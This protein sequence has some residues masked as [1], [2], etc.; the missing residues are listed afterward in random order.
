MAFDSMTLSAIV[1]ELR[2][3]LLGAKINK[4]HQPDPHTVLLKCH[5]QAGALRLLLSAHP[6]NGRIVCTE[7]NRE[8]PP[9]APLFL[10]VL[11]KWLEGARI[12]DFSCT[13]GERVATL[14]AE[15]RDELGDLQPLHLVTEIMGKHSN[16]ILY[17]REGVIIDGIRRYG[18]HLSRYREVLPGKPYLPPPPMDRLPLPP[19][20]EEALAELLYSH[21][22]QEISEI[23]R[24][25]IKG[26]SPLLAEHIL[27]EAGL[28]G[29]LSPD[30]MG[31]YEIHRI[32]SS[33]NDLGKMCREA[34][35][36]PQL[37]QVN[38]RFLDFAA[39]SPAFWPE[40]ERL[41]TASMNQAVDAFYQQREE[42][43]LFRRSANAL[44]R[45]L[46]QNL[47]RL[48]KKISLEE[49]DLYQSEAADAY[50]DCGDL[51]STYLWHLQKGMEQV[52]LPSFYD[53][54][55]KILVKL[56]PAL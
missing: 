12:T 54:E 38:G 20:S 52:E 49:A 3:R 24:R 42:E 15:C 50:K 41:E 11:R 34:R 14:D 16:I 37:R 31:E 53:P 44:N 27:T 1:A 25:G 36:Q 48:D 56:D 47:A 17:N 43:Q 21:G 23:L 28:D 19:D 22:E 7:S 5:S 51:L 29:E 6:E 39:L 33:L 4:I 32:Y 2:P 30:Q 55:E 35:F 45:S 26:L 18:S 13:D 40:D 9:K 8:N 10:M 46:R